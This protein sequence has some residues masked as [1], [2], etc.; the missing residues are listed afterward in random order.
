MIPVDAHTSTEAEWASVLFGL[1]L[2]LEKNCDDIAIENDHPGV[3][4]ALMTQK[5]RFR[6]EYA[7]H[8]HS[9]IITLAN[10]TSWIGVREHNKVCALFR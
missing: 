1:T 8:Y 7:R 3:I 4:R 2:A 10:E 6:H 5:P 9:Q